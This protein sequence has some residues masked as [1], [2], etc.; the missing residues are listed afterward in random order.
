LL[1]T[2]PEQREENRL[3]V[4]A[5]DAQIAKA[6]SLITQDV[7]PHDPALSILLITTNISVV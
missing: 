1:V 4:V 5:L 3:L 2:H 6:R 7:Q